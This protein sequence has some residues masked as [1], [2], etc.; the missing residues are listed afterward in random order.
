MAVRTFF[1]QPAEVRI[2]FFMTIDTPRGR[3]PEFFTGSMTVAALDGTMLAFEDEICGF[4]IEGFQV[5]LNDVRAP[6]FMVGVAVLALAPLHLGIAAM[7][8]SFPFEVN[9]HRLVAIQ[10]LLILPA[11]FEQNMT[12]GALR[13]VFG[14][15]LDHGPRH[16]KLFIRIGICL[17]RQQQ[18][19]YSC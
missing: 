16:Q 1:T 15:N 13:F 3:L 11:F 12:L 14:V 18:H 4:M 17:Q 19:Y 10:A 5:Q 2:I 6:A 9:T 8:T 7:K